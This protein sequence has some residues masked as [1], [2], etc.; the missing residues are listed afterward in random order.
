[1]NYNGASFVGYDSTDSVSLDPSSTI[2]LSSFEWLLATQESGAGPHTNGILGLCQNY[3]NG[4][5][6]TGPLLI[7]QL[8][9]AVSQIIFTK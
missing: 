2:A 5:Y 1:M 3:Q 9:D 8:Y 4:A 6:A 7:Q